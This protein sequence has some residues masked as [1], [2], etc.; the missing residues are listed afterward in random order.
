MISFNH[1]RNMKE[2]CTFVKSAVTTALIITGV[3]F[4]GITELKARTSFETRP[5]SGTKTLPSPNTVVNVA[6]LV[7]QVSPAVVSVMVTQRVQKAQFSGNGIHQ[8]EEFFE[9]FF[10]RKNMK[11]FRHNSPHGQETL[12]GRV[13]VVE[14][15]GSGFILDKEGIIV[16]NNHVIDG[17]DEIQVR[18][19]DG[20]KVTAKVIGKDVKT[21]LALLKVNAKD[22]LPA[23]AFGDSAKMRVGDWVLTMGNPFGIGKTATTGIISARHRNIGA[24]PFDD[25]L[26][27]DAPI[28]KG[29]SGGP[30]FNI[31][32]EVIGINTAIFSPSG[33][34]VGIGFAIP[35]S[36]AK[37]IIDDLRKEGK[38]KRGWLGVHI[39]EVTPELADSLGLD[40][41]EGALISRVMDGGP[42]DIAGL[43]SGDVVINVNGEV[44]RNLR[45]LP[46]FIASV[47]SGETVRISVWR[48]GKRKAIKVRIGST[49]TTE[50]VSGIDKRD[51]YGMQL[52]QLDEQERKGLGISNLIKGVVI[53][54][55]L[56]GTLASKTDLREG[57]VIVSVS[58]KMIEKPEDVSRVIEDAK[59]DDKRTVLLLIF[60]GAHEHFVALPIGNA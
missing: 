20:Q 53:R 8:F 23:V 4:A 49:P 37:E 22:E 58:K 59:E 10:D 2:S 18:L 12:N 16:T 29:N 14:G 24:G 31:Y 40:V 26:Q 46:R 3:T 42:A 52:A 41:P 19:H 57:D 32:G 44:I 43:Q 30:A 6:D 50:Q 55:I 27:I 35:S 7:E 21:D 11:K 56:P 34:S 28:N 39:Q 45:D 25:F 38:V 9:R 48:D 33:G 36:M 15:V 47:V 54:H 5:L 1:V 13:P 60:R 51:V 17:A